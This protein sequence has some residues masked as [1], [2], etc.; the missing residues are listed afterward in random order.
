MVGQKFEERLLLKIRSLR[1]FLISNIL[2][3]ATDRES[4]GWFNSL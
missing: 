2:D 1:D 4:G 3:P